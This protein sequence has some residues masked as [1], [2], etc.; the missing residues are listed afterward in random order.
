MLAG[1][2]SGGLPGWKLWAGFGV[3]NRFATLYLE[4]K[5][6]IGNRSCDDKDGVDP[7]EE[8]FNEAWALGVLQ[9]G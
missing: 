7:N 1:L 2:G 8:H 9:L 5:K 3:G 4:M 6:Q